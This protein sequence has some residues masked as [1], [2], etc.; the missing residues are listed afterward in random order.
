MPIEVK[1]PLGRLVPRTE[2]IKFHPKWAC[3]PPEL[4]KAVTAGAIIKVLAVSNTT[5][6]EIAEVL[7]VV[8]TR[9]NPKKKML[10]GRVN[11]HAE[12]TKYHGFVYGQEVKFPLSHIID[13][14]IMMKRTGIFK[15]K[16]KTP[17]AH[18]RPD[19][20]EMLKKRKGPQGR[21]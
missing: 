12:R 17:A 16:Q 3:T 5:P 10:E 18:M 21:T 19:H 11:T 1:E 15:N 13:V 20:K 9:I 14:G 7:W 2:A 8:V 6:K 4:I